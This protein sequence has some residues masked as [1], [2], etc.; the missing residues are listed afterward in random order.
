[1]V[2]WLVDHLVDVKAAMKDILWAA[3]MAAEN[4]EYLAAPTRVQQRECLRVLQKTSK[5]GPVLGRL[6]M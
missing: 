1:M 3:P 5:L 2:R 6:W 4:A